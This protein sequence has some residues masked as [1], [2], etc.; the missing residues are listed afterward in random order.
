MLKLVGGGKRPINP[1]PNLGYPLSI[2]TPDKSRFS[3][4]KVNQAQVINE[5]PN[6]FRVIT[7][8]IL[9]TIYLLMR[10]HNIVEVSGDKRGQ[11]L[12]HHSGDLG[13]KHPPLH[14]LGARVY[15]QQKLRAFSLL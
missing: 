14:I 1:P 4:A 5:L 8:N 7:I 13:A 10:S 6:F 12:C 15:T 2:V 9:P 11:A 3:I